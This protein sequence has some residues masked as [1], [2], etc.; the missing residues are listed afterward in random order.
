MFCCKVVRTVAHRTI[1]RHPVLW[2]QMSGEIVD[3]LL[4]NMELNMFGA[5]QSPAPVQPLVTSGF[6]ENIQY[7][8][9]LPPMRLAGIAEDAI[10][11][12]HQV[13]DLG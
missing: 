2:C 6:L 9:P 1:I 4:T 11:R 8:R 10:N 5:F 13:E 3:L 7:C 12:D